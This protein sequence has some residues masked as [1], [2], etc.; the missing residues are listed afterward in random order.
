MQD[1]SKSFFG[2]L[3][4][5]KVSFELHGGEVH[6]LLG[7]NGAGKSTLIKILAGAY[8]ADSG[9]ILLEGQPIPIPYGPKAA[10][11]LGIAT[12]YQHF[13]LLPHLTV[14][15][16]LAMR[17]FVHDR[18][19]FVDWSGMRAKAAEALGKLDF[20]ISP[21]ARIKELSV[22]QR[23]MLEIAIALTK[24]AKLLVM[25]E[26]TAALSTK[27]IDHLFTIIKQL[28][29]RGLGLIYVSHKLE[30]VKNIADRMTILRDGNWVATL[31][32][33]EAPIQ[34]IVA[35]MVGGV[36]AN[37]TLQTRDTSDTLL[38]VRGLHTAHL[39]KPL[40]FEIRTN[41][42]LGVTGLIGAGKTELARALFGVDPVAAG[43]IRFKDQPLHFKRP[44]DAVRFGVGYVPEDRDQLGLCLN[45]SVGENLI[46]AEL[47][48][49]RGIFFS[50]A[51]A[52]RNVAH[53]IR[54]MRIRTAGSAQLVKYLSGGNKQKVVLGKWLASKCELLILDEPT[55]GIDIGARQEIYHLI[56]DFVEQPE[57]AVILLSSD[58]EE[59]LA[60]ADRIL[61][62]TERQ[63]VA[64]LD[65]QRT[66]KQE[67]F[68]LSA[69]GRVE[70]S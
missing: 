21:T 12:I 62:L 32:A 67:I 43:E 28:R 10:E 65:P 51:L 66:S 57:H 13:H 60:I 25:D 14:A 4:L 29:G 61:V 39:P 33:P 1:I 19:W 42:I 36:T 30:E 59:I 56:R 68:A 49:L 41:E 9:T 8:S 48:R 38:S 63:V 54:S 47:A 22:A 35:L 5:K 52:R 3:A 17:S 11:D 70:T 18:G 23:Q 31:N 20:P 2:V 6:A 34:Q 45:L 40:T 53:A 26:P 64:E 58:I 7:E 37:S 27:E 50:R 46:L 55:I 69:Q 16:N 15:E 44:R 24:K